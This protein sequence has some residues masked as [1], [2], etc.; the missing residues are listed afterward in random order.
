MSVPTGSAFYRPST[1]LPR[2]PL[3]L[4]GDCVQALARGDEKC[5]HVLP[6]EADIGCPQLW[7]RD[8]SHLFAGLVEYRD[9]PTG[10]VDISG[11]V[12]RHPVRPQPTELP[13][14]LERPVRLDVVGI[15]FV[16][17]DV[18][19]IKGLPVRG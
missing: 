19:H 10:E 2:S 16:T 9:P 1:S 7:D 17:P 14:V 6:A 13:P 5:F 3:H 4:H 11:L 12:D 8:V 18:G 15:R